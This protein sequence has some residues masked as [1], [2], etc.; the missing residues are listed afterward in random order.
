[1]GLWELIYSAAVSLRTPYGDFTAL[2]N[3]QYA[4]G[5]PYFIELATK[6]TPFQVS[7]DRCAT[8]PVFRRFSAP[9]TTIR[10]PTSAGVCAVR[11]DH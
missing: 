10:V 7:T 6:F 4:D 9:S 2:S 11:T 1:M 3:E 5:I 8:I